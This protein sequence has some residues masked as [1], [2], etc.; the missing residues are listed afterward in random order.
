VQLFGHFPT[1]K[2]FTDILFD[3]AVEKADGNQSLASRLLG[4]NQSTLSRR[5]AKRD[6]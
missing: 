6:V 3:A 4:V 5:L 2:E 1:V